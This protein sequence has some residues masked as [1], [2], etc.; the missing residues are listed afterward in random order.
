MVKLPVSNTSAPLDVD[1]K[2]EP[3]SLSFSFIEASLV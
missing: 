1:I 3:N 2:E